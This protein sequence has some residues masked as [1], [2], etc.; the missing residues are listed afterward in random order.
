MKLYEIP[1]EFALLEK[2]LV[3]NDGELT[4]E[5]E[6][7]LDDFLRSGKDKIEGGAMVMRGLEIE[8]EACRAEAKRL[9]ERASSLDNNASRLKRLILYALDGAFGGKIKTALFTIWGQTSATTTNLD[10]EPGADLKLLPE[11][12]VRVKYELAK[13]AVKDALKKGV[14]IPAEIIVTEM[15]GTRFLRVK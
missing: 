10:L 13:D 14:E 12:F 8:A 15:P 7:S 1:T 9:T 4:P 3:E 11:Q 2:V 5:L 6:K